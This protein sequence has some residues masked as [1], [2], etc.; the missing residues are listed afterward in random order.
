MNKL[1]FNT[2]LKEIENFIEKIEV[3]QEKLSENYFE[4]KKIQ[5]LKED[6]LSLFKDVI[7][8][9]ESYC[10]LTFAVKIFEKELG[11]LL[12]AI[13]SD[14]RSLIKA[15]FS[16]NDS[17]ILKYKEFYKKL[18]DTSNYDEI[19]SLY[20][21]FKK[22]NLKSD[23]EN[24]Y[25]D[26]FT[27]FSKNHEIFKNINLEDDRYLFKYGKYISDNEIK[28][29]N[30]MRKYPKDKLQNLAKIIV[31]GYIRGFEKDNK[32]IT[33]RHK[34]RVIYNIGQ[35]LLIKEIFDLFEKSN[36]QGIAVLAETT[37]PNKQYEYDH[38]FDKALYFDEDFINLEKEILNNMNKEITKEMLDCSGILYIEKF[39]EIPFIPES[40]SENLK[41]SE[42]Q[43]KLAN[44]ENI[45]KKQ[46]VET[47]FSNKERS[48]CIVAFPS[49]EIGENFEEIYEDTCKI[50]SLDSSIY[51]PIQQVIIDNLD[52]G[53]FVRV[54]GQHGNETDIFVKMPKINNP[55]KETNYFNC[56]ADVNIP[57]GE[58]FTTPELEGT[59]GLLHLKNVYLNDLEF[60]NLKLTFENGYIK[61][62]SCTNFEKVEDNKKYIE[63]NLI[64]P[65]KTLPIGEFA[66]GTNT[67]A[68]V[69][70]KKHNIVSKLPILIVEKM[71]P[72]FAIG[73]TCYSWSE[74]LPVYNPDGKEIIARD[75]CH[76]LQRKTDINKAYTNVHTDI[77]LPYDELEYI[78]VITYD[79]KEIEIIKEG[80]FVLE[81]TEYLNEAF[82]G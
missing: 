67:L 6:N 54:K 5:E 16:K 60:L 20:K 61:E 23:L 2:Y 35:E 11:Q 50:N 78:K 21:N 62:Y 66:I 76:S 31:E 30:F 13:Y 8:Y 22:E 25:S 9:N 19:L 28:L 73:D 27:P 68:Y 72:H 71:G 42:E 51:E 52:K 56:T 10:N 77:T 29:M 81:G 1:E 69:I 37:S 44:N 82:R 14:F 64:F 45:M 18:S 15:V 43:T 38:N 24:F 58:I 26:N 7:E 41:Y 32:D 40:K 79:K 36:L 70:A 17:T 55:E 34:V 80:R 59:N 74:D 4:G 12:S 39:G 33:L 65:H 46:F 63:E 48:F 53:E 57:L 75:N 3:F 47:Y 49:P